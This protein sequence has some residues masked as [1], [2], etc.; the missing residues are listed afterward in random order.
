M[1]FDLTDLRLFL[2]VHEA[3][4]I[5]GGAE[6]THMTLASASERIRG[7]ED[8]LGTKLLLRD[9]RGVQ[10]T[11]AGRT[12]VHHAR[13]VLQQIDRMQ[14]ELGDYGKG[15]KGHIRLLCNTSALSEHLPEVLSTFLTQHPGI[16]IDLEERPSNEIIDAVR[17]QTC[18]IGIAS[19]TENLE[20]QETF[21]FR[22]DPLVLIV[23]HQHPLAQHS[24][25]CLA[26]ILDY[27]FVGLAEG[28]ALYQHIAQHARH[29]G[30]QLNYRI[31]LRSLETVCRMVG[32]GI[33]IAIVPQAVALRC[34]P[35]A[36]IKPIT[37]TD[38]WATRNLV[39]CLRQLDQLPTHT[40]QLIQ[41]ILTPV[42]DERL[43]K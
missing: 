19:D 4:T 41:H 17:N 7:M 14:G 36:R 5:T 43:L 26:E 12:L 20:G 16:S 37:L 11:P 30:K 9:R 22:S 3:G 1:R 24:C 33:G 35:S 6:S 25:S 28:S 40:Q 21:P 27:P 32:L 18:D 13:L 8:R 38:T 23:P 34:T 39:L 15:L 42:P 31:R 10:V 2:N 29:Q